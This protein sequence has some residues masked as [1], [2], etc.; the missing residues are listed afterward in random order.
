[1]MASKGGGCGRALLRNYPWGRDNQSK[2]GV[3]RNFYTQR[4]VRALHISGRDIR[5][6]AITANHTR[7]LHNQHR[8]TYYTSSDGKKYDKTIWSNLGI[9]II[10]QQTAYIIERLGKYK[11]TLLAGIHFIIPFIDKI[12]YVFSLKE[13]TITIPNQTAI[14][15]D[16]VT[17]NIDG[18]L[19]I[20]C[21]NPYN[22][23]YGIEDAFFAVTQLAQVTMRSELGKLTLDATFLERDNLN[24]KI[25]K[26]INE[27]SK[28][29]G[30]KCMRY[31]IRDIILPVN[32]K[33]AMEK[34]AEAE[35]RKR[36]EILQSE[37]ERESEINIAIGKKKKSILIA[38]G[39]SF[40]IKA[41]ADATAEAIEIISNKIKKLDSNSAISLL[42][43]EQYID[44]FSNICKNNNTVIIPADLNNI[45]SLI[46]QSLSIY[47]NI[48]NAKRG[49]SPPQIEA[50]PH[51]DLA[52]S[53]AKD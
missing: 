28:N 23:S 49:S 34:Q 27:S 39:Q 14:T 36:A 32:I 25:V 47:N 2:L 5:I 9:V 33:N 43:A 38:E 48:Q 30:I 20:K 42:I 37:G 1:M 44:V 7:A 22:S 31:E 51:D 15:K 24:E 16:N 35:R 6:G 52:H 4:T 53:E 19:Y 11:K 26:A 10:P 8:C 18:V 12:A 50:L 17:L 3:A 40:A 13:E 45:S 41:K 46:S 29:W 21:E